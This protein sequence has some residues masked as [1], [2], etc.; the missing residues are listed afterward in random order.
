MSMSETDH[1]QAAEVRHYRHLWSAVVLQAKDDIENLSLDS[2]E[3]EQAVAFFIGRGDWVQNRTAIGDFLN[4]H[5][6]DLEKAGRRCINRRRVSEGLEPLLAKQPWPTTVRSPRTVEHRSEPEPATPS[7]SPLQIDTFFP[8]G[9][10][11]PLMSGDQ[12]A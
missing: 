3:F 10:Y 1:T 7:P 9:T 11:V 2:V 12:A 4:L 5:R 6:D 8:C